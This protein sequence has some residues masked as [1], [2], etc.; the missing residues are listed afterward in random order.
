MISYLFYRLGEALALTLPLKLAYAL[1]TFLSYVYYIFAFR[2]RRQVTDNLRVI[3]PLKN[4][5]DIASIRF[6]VFR[7]FAKYLVD[8][9]RFDKLDANY[10]KDNVKLFGLDN[11]KEG[12]SLGKGAILLTA[13]LGNWELGG[14]VL[15]LSGY[16]FLTVTLSH[17][18]KEVT[19]FFDEKRESKGLKILSLGNAAKGCFKALKENQLIALLGDRDFTEKGRVMDFFGKPVFLPE[20]A[21]FLSLKTGA[22]IIPGFML[23]N[24]DDTFSLIIEK[25][26][27]FT[28]SGNREKDLEIIMFKCKGVFEKYIRS[29]PDQWYMFRRF[30]RE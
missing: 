4:K 11:I 5:K 10:V 24:K 22:A 8:F 2:D 25:S 29:Y 13:H 17:K 16:P 21:A 6:M 14:L 26:L 28:L 1:A 27:E 3:F 19:K 9:F 7:N 30:W 12:L 20:G 23:R 18:S 15:S